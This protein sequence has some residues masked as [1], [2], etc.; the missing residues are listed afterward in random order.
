MKVTSKRYYGSTCHIVEFMPTELRLEDTPGIPGKRE[1][2]SKIFGDP[3][4]DEVTWLR[5]NR[6]F[7][8]TQNSKSESMGDGL[9]DAFV[10][11]GY[12]DGKLYLEP[13]IPLNAEWSVGTSYMLLRD[14]QYSYDNEHHFFR[15]PRQTSPDLLWPEAKRYYSFHSCRWPAHE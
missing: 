4:L 5:V 7:F 9:G 14:G 6:A 15:H 10:N 1:Y 12:K 8:D 13:N 11:A 3:H 2:I